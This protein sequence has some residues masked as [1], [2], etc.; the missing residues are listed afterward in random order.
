[1]GGALVKFRVVCQDSSGRRTTVTVTADTDEKACA[2]AL[3]GLNSWRAVRA[4][5]PREAEPT[6]APA[7][8]PAASQ[9]PVP[10]PP[11]D[12]PK[13]SRVQG[14]RIVHKAGPRDW[15]DPTMRQPKTNM[16]RALLEA[17]REVA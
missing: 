4:L 14:L 11:E 7:A 16:G 6:P 1:V 12:R 15:I 5:S 17:R 9:P 10:R 13:P 2:A 8:A 3:A